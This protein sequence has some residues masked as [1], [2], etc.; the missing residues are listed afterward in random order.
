MRL[1]IPQFKTDKELHRYLVTN[2]EK[3]KAQKMASVKFADGFGYSAVKLASGATERGQYT[4]KSNE[5]VPDLETRSFLDTRVIINTTRLLDGHRDVHI[6]GLW[7]DELK[8]MADQ[9][10]HVQEHKSWQF[11][12]LISDGPDL[13]AYVADRTWAEL[14]FDY[15]GKTQALT[16]DSRVWKS[17]NEFMFEQYGKGYVKQH[18]VG[19]YY[20]EIV[21]CIRDED[22]EE[23]FANWN[24]YYPV[25]ANKED[26]ENISYFWAV[27]K[28]T[29]F[30][31]SA[32]P[33]GSNWVSPTD[34]ND[35]KAVVE[36]SE[37]EPTSSKELDALNDLLTKIQS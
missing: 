13:K 34:E 24:T 32:V 36:P 29:P 12:H 27:L 17:R 6:D 14:G 37:Q 33:R 9:V 23:E 10:L 22:Y 35:M 30:E 21:F 31:G 7:D 16:F 3:L 5:P 15:E 26:T 8:R 1:N 20:K 19:M 11:D 25:I 4:V 18:S 28:A 2:K